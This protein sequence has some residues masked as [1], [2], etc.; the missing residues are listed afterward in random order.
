MLQ[1]YNFKSYSRL[2]IIGEP[3]RKT[4]SSSKS[5]MGFLPK[6]VGVMA[7]LSMNEVL[8]PAN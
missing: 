8:P 7:P 2:T 1:V 4:F 3:H 6:I 5:Y